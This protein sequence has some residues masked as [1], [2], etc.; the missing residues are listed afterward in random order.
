MEE[1]RNHVDLRDLV[2]AATTGLMPHIADRI[3][4]IARRAY[5]LGCVDGM[6]VQKQLD[7]E[8]AA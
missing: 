4:D 6:E 5:Y 8:N 7:K 1:K 3:K 2:D